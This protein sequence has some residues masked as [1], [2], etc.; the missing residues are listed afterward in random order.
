MEIPERHWAFFGRAMLLVSGI[1][2][3]LF[4][5]YAKED[6]IHWFMELWVVLLGVVAI[7]VFF[8]SRGN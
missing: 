4:P 3:I 5:F 2:L 1:I 7:L 8:A 6:F